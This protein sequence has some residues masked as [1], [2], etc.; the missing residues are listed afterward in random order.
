M[1]TQALRE[2][3]QNQI[4]SKL[5]LSDAECGM[6]DTGQPPT[7]YTQK[8]YIAV[9]A[10]SWRAEQLDY[11]MR[12]RIGCRVTVSYRGTQFQYDKWEF[13]TG[14]L[15]EGV[16][17][18][19]RKVIWAIA[20]YPILLI[21]SANRLISQSPPGASS[22]QFVNGEFLRWQH[23]DLVTPRKADWW[24]ASDPQARK[25]GMSQTIIF[26]GALRVQAMS[27]FQ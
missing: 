13:V 15:E 17:F 12:E 6:Q 7:G 23:C 27:E 10:G 16:E 21:D 24:G 19:S 22:S 18:I 11:G 14:T 4:R 9:H 3:V 2:A 20:T 5:G 1:S 25:A 8:M 26:D